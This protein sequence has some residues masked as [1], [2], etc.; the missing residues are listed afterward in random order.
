VHLRFVGVDAPLGADG[1]PD[2]GS[3]GGK[4]ARGR[5]EGRRDAGSSPRAPGSAPAEAACAAGPRQA[6]SPGRL[7]DGLLRAVADYPRRNPFTAG[8]LVVLLLT[9]WLVDQLSEPT[10]SGLLQSISTNLDNMTTHPVFSLVAS[11]LVPADGLRPAVLVGVVGC[12]AWLERAFGAR[13]AFSVYAAGHVAGTLLSLVVIML[14][15]RAGGYPDE[16][17]GALDYGVSYGAVAAFTA[18]S[19]SLPRWLGVPWAVAGVAY[20]FTETTWIGALPDFTTFGHCTAALTGLGAA[21]WLW[22]APRPAPNRSSSEPSAP[23]GGDFG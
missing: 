10:E 9:S 15:V 19:S 2:A 14:A 7:I 17:R 20:A 11:A 12:L 16:V 22:R 8:Y 18:V 4:P 13:R 3:T 1:H 21:L 23:I 5:A 6:A